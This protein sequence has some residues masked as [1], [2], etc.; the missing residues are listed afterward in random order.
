[1]IEKVL[2]ASGGNT[3]LAAERLGISRSTLYRK[4]QQYRDAD[5]A[6]EPGDATEG[7]K[8]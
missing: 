7:R 2:A 4:L 6:G 1:L 8:P 3:S 5:A